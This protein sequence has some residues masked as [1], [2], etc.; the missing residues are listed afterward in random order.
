[1]KAV[2][3]TKDIHRQ[4]RRIVALL[5]AFADLAERA[6]GRSGLVR[7]LAV[8]FLRQAEGLARHHVLALTGRVARRPALPD[9]ADA[10]AEALSLAAR[11]RAL[12]SALAAFANAVMVSGM[13]AVA[14]TLPALAGAATALAA[15]S[16]A[17]AR[18]DTS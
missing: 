6:A 10:E 13:A 15:I 14:G 8:W 7:L 5:L 17:V 4:L 11:F 18:L 3:G 12:A 16:S 9:G 1:M 2:T